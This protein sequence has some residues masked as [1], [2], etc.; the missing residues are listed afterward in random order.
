[1]SLSVL[2]SACGGSDTS[3]PV[4]ACNSFAAALCNK[5]TSCNVPGVTSACASNVSVALNCAQAACSS[6]K[7][8]SG[9]ASSCISAINGLTCTEATNDFNNQTV[10]SVCNSVCQ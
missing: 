3:N 1:M 5:A 8:N 4:A 2:W 9:A 7:F 10:P 6:G